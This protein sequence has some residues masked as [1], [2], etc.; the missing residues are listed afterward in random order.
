MRLVIERSEVRFGCESMMLGQRRVVRRA[1]KRAVTE[2]ENVPSI[3]WERLGTLWRVVVRPDMRDLVVSWRCH[4][5]FV[6]RG[7]SRVLAL[8][9]VRF[10]VRVWIRHLGALC[11]GARFSPLVSS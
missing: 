3:A 11:F 5:F 9:D 8:W 6:L 2:G 4:F 1:R 10:S 7:P